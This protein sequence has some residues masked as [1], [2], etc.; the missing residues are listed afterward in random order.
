[1]EN[2][3]ADRGLKW[4]NGVKQWNGRK[5]WRHERMN[6]N[7]KIHLKINNN[8]YNW[9]AILASSLPKLVFN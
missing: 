2:K 3:E 6:V 8:N 1:M 7:W 5:E 9:F 4:K